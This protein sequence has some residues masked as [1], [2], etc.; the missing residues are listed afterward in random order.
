MI[1]SFSPP[2]RP[3]TAALPPSATVIPVSSADLPPA[4]SSVA[5][6]PHCAATL[7]AVVA[8]DEVH[9]GMVLR[10]EMSMTHE[11]LESDGPIKISILLDVFTRKHT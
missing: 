3:V 9:L 4:N 10:L 8:V 2:A 6:L 1:K 7:T 11:V 5:A